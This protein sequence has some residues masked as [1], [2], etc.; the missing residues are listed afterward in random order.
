MTVDWTAQT[1]FVGVVTRGNRRLE[2][3]VQLALGEWQVAAL[4]SSVEEI[5]ELTRIGHYPSPAEAMA[6]AE[7]FGAR[8]LLGASDTVP[9]PSPEER[10]SP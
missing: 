6:A 4:V 1:Q 8:W 3:V 9:C 2:L 7:S 5:E 10:P